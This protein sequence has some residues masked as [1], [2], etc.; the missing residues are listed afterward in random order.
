MGFFERAAELIFPSNIYCIACGNAIDATR[1]YALC[2]RCMNEI[3]WNT[4]KVC[5]KCGRSIENDRTG[6]EA[7]EAEPSG[8]QGALCFDCEATSHVFRKGYACV[9]YSGNAKEIVRSLKYRDNPYI[10]EKLA[11]IMWERIREEID[12]ETGEV[13]TPDLILPVPMHI[14]KRR[15]RGYDQAVLMARRLSARME[16]PCDENCI[17]RSDATSVM[18]SLGRSERKFN[19]SGAFS[20]AEGAEA[21]V[22]GKDLLLVDDV[23]TTGSTADACAS[24]LLSAGAAGVDIFVFASGMNMRIKQTN[25]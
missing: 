4:G 25:N 1:A 2:D 9:T 8:E 12:E 13:F 10:A 24:T 14:I 17:I 19:V 23:F 6:D 16:V 21:R 20:L 22:A 3:E 7:P 5:A 18:S 11:K 15:K